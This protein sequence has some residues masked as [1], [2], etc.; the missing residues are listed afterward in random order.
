MGLGAHRVT[1]VG[2][3]ALKT[4]VAHL[5]AKYAIKWLYYVRYTRMKSWV[6]GSALPLVHQW[7]LL[8]LALSLSL[9]LDTA[10]AGPGIVELRA[11]MIVA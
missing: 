7:D 5:V 9:S 4:R 11:I 2:S 3:T 8:V 1:R 10:D 6:G